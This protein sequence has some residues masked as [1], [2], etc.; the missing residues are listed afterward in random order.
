MATT[1]DHD[2]YANGS[3]WVDEL[4]EEEGIDRDLIVTETRR[5][6]AHLKKLG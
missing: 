2:V 5:V 1:L 3:A 6:L 4:V